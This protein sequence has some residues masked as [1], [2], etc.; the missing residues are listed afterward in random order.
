MA[1]RR[2]GC[3]G[4]LLKLL[5]LC[6]GITAALYFFSSRFNT[7]F[8]DPLQHAVSSAQT[9]TS[10]QA[11]Q[12]PVSQPQDTSVLS[13]YETL[14]E[15]DR[16]IYDD[17]YTAV[18][19]FEPYSYTAEHF[20]KYSDSI[21][22]RLFTI[23]QYVLYDHPEIFWVSASGSITFDGIRTYV[24]EPDYYFTANE[25]D[26]YTQQL[27]Q[28][29]ASITADV[30]A[31][32][33]Y[34]KVIWAYEWIIRSTTYDHAL[35]SSDDMSAASALERSALGCFLQGKT[36]CSGY[37][38]AF[39]LLMQ[40]FGIPCTYLSGVITDNGGRHAWNLVM[41][42]GNCYHVDT[43]WGDPAYSGAETDDQSVSYSY[44]CLTDAQI[45]RTRTISEDGRFPAATDTKYNYYLYHD[46]Y[47]DAVSDEAIQRIVQNAVDTE[48]RMVSMQFASEELLQQA[49]ETYINQQRIYTVISG[50]P[51]QLVYSIDS[52]SYVLSL[53][54][55]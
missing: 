17:F 24:C 31:Q 48:Q 23:L 26:A 11:H 1:T 7:W 25:A 53:W 45:K 42:N 37:A 39:Q 22:E 40:H 44:L 32:S 6:A 51:R 35:A 16:A 28:K 34:E 13:Y 10:S 47:L 21:K 38:Q 52:S 54:L 15:S 14:T 46:L 55:Q 50:L 19:A 18:Q 3:S 27:E 4:C 20:G 49:V 33:D 36:I 43:T 8:D 29:I 9:V 12:E 41:I 5:L 2:G 30:T